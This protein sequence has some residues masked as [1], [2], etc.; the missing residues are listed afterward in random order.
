MVFVLTAFIIMGGL[1]RGFEK[2][3][4]TVFAFMLITGVLVNTHTV[5]S[6][7]AQLTIAPLSGPEIRATIYGTTMSGEYPSGQ[8]WSE[9]FNLDGTSTYVELGKISE[10]KMSL[11]GNILCFTYKN[12]DQFGGCFEV[13][14]RGPNCFDFYSSS[15]NAS[16]D[17]RQFGKRWDARAWHTDRPSTCVSEQIS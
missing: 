9:R 10:G 14:K 8:N 13:W 17:N 15:S 16:L 7:H 4:N 3:S 2:M 11:N 12:D 1:L 6:T 5:R